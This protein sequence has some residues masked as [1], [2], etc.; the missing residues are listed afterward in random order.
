LSW[1]VK[2]FLCQLKIL[3]LHVSPEIKEIFDLVES[4]KNLSE[5]VTIKCFNF[6]GEKISPQNERT[7]GQICCDYKIDPR[8]ALMIIGVEL[9][10]MIRGEESKVF[11]KDSWTMFFINNDYVVVCG[12]RDNGLAPPWRMYVRKSDDTALLYHG[13]KS[14]FSSVTKELD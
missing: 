12:W 8:V 2:K 14:I 10:K 1:L 4:S 5:A 13:I 7:M 9:V 6:L 3:R 11:K